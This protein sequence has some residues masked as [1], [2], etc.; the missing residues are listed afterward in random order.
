MEIRIKRIGRNDFVVDAP[1]LREAYLCEADLREADL[2]GADL[3]GADLREAIR[4]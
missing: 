2:E 1:S 3:R 4:D